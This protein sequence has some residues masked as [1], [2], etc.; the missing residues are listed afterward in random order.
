MKTNLYL[1]I[2]LTSLLLLPTPIFAQDME[3]STPTPGK[4]VKFIQQG[5]SRNFERRYK[6]LES[7]EEEIQK[8]LE[9]KQKKGLDILPI[10]AELDNL[11]PEKEEFKANLET[12][13]Q[14]STSSQLTRL[15]QSASK[16]QTN[17]TQIRK[18]QLKALKTLMHLK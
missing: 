13:N 9:S 15:R 3:K 1:T 12:F 5:L 14:A 2:A 7:T 4:G 16:I 6:F 17:L 11:Q 10:K 8:K 18:T